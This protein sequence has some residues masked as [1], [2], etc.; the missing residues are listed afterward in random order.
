MWSPA[1]TVPK[2]STRRPKIG[3]TVG[4]ALSSRK[5]TN[6]KFLI[7][8]LENAVPVKEAAAR[9]PGARLIEF[10]DLG[11]SPQIQATEAFHR[12][13]LKALQPASTSSTKWFA[14]ALGP[15]SMSI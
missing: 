1:W 6:S 13:L 14:S 2:Q 9:I 12:E 4:S 3:S 8:S 11:H 15:E 5:D 10:P 7:L